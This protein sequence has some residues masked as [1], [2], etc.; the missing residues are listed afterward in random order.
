MY[1]C[2]F[3]IIKTQVICR[4]PRKLYET[5]KTVYNKYW[6]LVAKYLVCAEK[7]LLIRRVAC[8]TTRRRMVSNKGR[9]VYAFHDNGY[10]SAIKSNRREL[11]KCLNG[12]ILNKLQNICIHYLASIWYCLNLVL[13]PHYS[14]DFHFSSNSVALTNS[15]QQLFSP[16]PSPSCTEETHK[17]IYFKYF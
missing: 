12:I 3:F 5:Q 17:H 6:Q 8:H 2:T 13:S 11:A 10:L 9:K 4:T 14:T 7:K 15:G 1:I 16:L